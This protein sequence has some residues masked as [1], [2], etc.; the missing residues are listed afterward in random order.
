MSQFFQVMSD[1]NIPSDV[2]TS[3]SVSNGNVI[4]SAHIVII[5]TSAGLVATAN[6]ASSN[7]LLLTLNEVA[8]AYT[9]ITGV[10]SYVVI[11]NDYY[12]S[13]DTSGGPVTINLPN[14]TTS[15][16]QLI[17]K[18]RTGNSSSNNVTIQSVTPGTAKIDGKDDYVFTDNFESIELLFNGT[19]YE[20]F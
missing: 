14:T 3:F 6:P 4:P 10:S 8:P 20:S 11:D 13:I 5:E 1:S 18:D 17:I 2:P 19:N 9:N 15:Y 7:N 16:R 12:I